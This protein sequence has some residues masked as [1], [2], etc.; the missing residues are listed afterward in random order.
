MIKRVLLQEMVV[1][2][3]VELCSVQD[4][5]TILYEV[6]VYDLIENDII[7]KQIFKTRQLAERIYKK[8]ISEVK[9]NQKVI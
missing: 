4:G 2:Y 1:N 5:D 7:G 6:F 8:Y 9:T 3:G